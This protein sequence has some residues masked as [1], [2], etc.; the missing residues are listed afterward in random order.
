MQIKDLQHNNFIAQLSELL[1]KIAGMYG[2]KECEPGFVAF[3]ANTLKKYFNHL[4]IEQIDMAFE[5]NSIGSL[6]EYLPKKGFSVDNKV[7]YTIPD[8]IK[9]IKAY[10]LLKNIET[11]KPKECE[12]SHEKIIESHRLWCNWFI[13]VFERY[14]ESYERS[15][16]VCPKYACEVLAEISLI[17]PDLI[18]NVAIPLNITIGKNKQPKIN[19]NE[20]LIYQTFDKIIDRGQHLN[21][22]L[23][24]YRNKYNTE[25]PY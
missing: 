9:I 12:L 17:T 16:I 13:G 8:M 1:T 25:I 2:L 11:E 7:D 6:K 24:S 5:Y 3:F 21:N 23:A 20:E 15:I 19:K 18:D 10:T 14:Y 22:L 4:T